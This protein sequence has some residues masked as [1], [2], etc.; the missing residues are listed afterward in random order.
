[1]ARWLLFL[2]GC[3]PLLAQAQAPTSRDS[4]FTR[5]LRTPQTNAVRDSLW[6]IVGKAPPA[7]RDSLRRLVLAT[8]SLHS[9]IVPGRTS[10]FTAGHMYFGDSNGEGHVRFR[11]WAGD[12]GCD[13]RQVEA[14]L[15]KADTTDF[16]DWAPR[17]PRV[18]EPACVLLL[19][20][21]VPDRKRRISNASGET[22]VWSYGSGGT[23]LTVW[24]AWNGHRWIITQMVE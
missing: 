22:E 21:G 15:A 6:D 1:M 23:G 3:L 14:T 20:H 8:P 4:V 13:S 18:G 9:D 16:S 17:R 5:L 10:R 11:S 19:A 24:L 12:Y 7:Q 2:I